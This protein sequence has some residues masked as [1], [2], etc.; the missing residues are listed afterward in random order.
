MTLRFLATETGRMVL[1]FPE[2]EKLWGENRLSFGV[3]VVRWKIKRS[4]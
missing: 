2:L 1:T 4:V 3:V